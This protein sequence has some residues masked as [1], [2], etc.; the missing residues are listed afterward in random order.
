MRISIT[1]CG[2]ACVILDFGNYRILLDPFFERNPKSMPLL[3]L[4][5]EE[6]Q[7]ID[8]ILVSHG[9]FDHITSAPY[10]LHRDRCRVLGNAQVKINIERIGSGKLLPELPDCIDKGD[11]NNI[12]IVNPDIVYSLRKN[13]ETLATVTP[14]QS[15]HIQFDVHE[16]N[17]V[18][19]N[20]EVWSHAGRFLSYWI[21]LPKGKVL[22]YE[23]KYQG[24]RIIIFGSLNFKKLDTFEKYR[25]CDLLFIPLAGRNDVTNPGI[26]VT[27]YFQPKIV[28][29]SH[30]DNFFP[31]ISQWTDISKY[32][33]RVK[34][35][36]PDTQVIMPDIGI[37]RV[38]DL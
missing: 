30:Y 16:I 2:T 26:R 21:G 5:K 29:P 18:A 3:P 20:W 38:V 23:I 31:P 28:I 34:Q 25:P 1:W 14:I 35:E 22:G 9:H 8:A 7:K 4:K 33:V 11:L 24:K 19:F 6:V 12:D 10:F 17:R 27:R 37:P 13:G 36:M 32:K 15:C